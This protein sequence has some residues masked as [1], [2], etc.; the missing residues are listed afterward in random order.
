MQDELGDTL[1][2]W[3]LLDLAQE[4]VSLNRELREVRQSYQQLADAHLAAVCKL[5][6]I[7]GV[8]KRHT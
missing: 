7:E 3:R 1:R 6:E 8:L 2:E 4:I 5:E